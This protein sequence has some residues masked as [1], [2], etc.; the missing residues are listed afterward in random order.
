MTQAMVEKDVTDFKSELGNLLFKIYK[1]LYTN[2][3]KKEADSSF[4]K[5]TMYFDDKS[6][7]NLLRG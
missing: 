6:F 3:G 5:L 2:Y 7:M 4:E 1:A